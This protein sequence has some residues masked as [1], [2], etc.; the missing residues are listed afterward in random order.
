MRPFSKSG[1]LVLTDAVM[2][3]ISACNIYTESSSFGK[4]SPECQ[5][6]LINAVFRP[7][8]GI[9]NAEPA[10]KNVKEVKPMINRTFGYVSIGAMEQNEDRQVELLLAA[11]VD[12]RDIFIDRANGRDLSRSEYQ[13]LLRVLREGDTLIIKSVDRLG[14]NYNEITEQ[15]QVITKEIKAYIKVLDMP[16]I[17]TTVGNGDLSGAFISDLVLQILSYVAETERL[18]LKQRQAEGFRLAKEAGRHLGRPK[19]EFPS[20]FDEY[21]SSWKRGEMTATAAMEHL[22][23]KRT[24]FYKLVKIKEKKLV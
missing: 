21:Y 23:L 14:R 12:E 9:D 24:T 15:W 20:N 2:G 22:K 18:N 7:M 1:I 17:D 19:A 11:G 3:E 10:L 16:L 13:V 8:I 5:Q 6:A 4:R